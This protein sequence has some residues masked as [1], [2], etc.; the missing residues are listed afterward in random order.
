[1]VAVSPHTGFHV[2]SKVDVD[3]FWMTK[4]SMR[5]VS[6]IPLLA[7]LSLASSRPRL[8]DRLGF[9]LTEESEP[10]KRYELDLC[11]FEKPDTSLYENV[12]F[13]A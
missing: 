12:Q 5:S 4:P 1:M 7:C 2:S 8:Y 6:S 11:G 10:G 9:T 3:V 13:E